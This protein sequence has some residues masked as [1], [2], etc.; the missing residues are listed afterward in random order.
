MTKEQR[1]K[2]LKELLKQLTPEQ[3]NSFIEW[4]ERKGYACKTN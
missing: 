2:R 1:E 4:M 3:L